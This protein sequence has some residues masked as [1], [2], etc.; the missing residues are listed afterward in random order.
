MR[1]NINERESELLQRGLFALV[2]KLEKDGVL[3]DAIVQ[4]YLDIKELK[5]KIKIDVV[6][7]IPKKIYINIDGHEEDLDLDY[8]E[9]TLKGILLSHEGHS[10]VFFYYK[11]AGKL[12]EVDLHCNAT[13]ELKD[14]I[15][16]FLGKGTVKIV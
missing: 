7:E 11:E 10:K 6:Y 4:D 13:G 8:M 3:S 12:S 16:D 14:E 15:E 9:Q 1:I 5:S 2:K